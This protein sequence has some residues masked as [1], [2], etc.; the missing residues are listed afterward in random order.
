LTLGSISEK[1]GNYPLQNATGGN[2]SF[3]FNQPGYEE[4]PKAVAK[5]IDTATESYIYCPK[6]PLLIGIVFI[7][8]QKKT[9]VNLNLW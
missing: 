8:L 7:L 3:V 4:R 2:K 1:E 5:N 9:L 6:I